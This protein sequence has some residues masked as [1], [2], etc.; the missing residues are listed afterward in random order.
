MN[1]Y[2]IRKIKDLRKISAI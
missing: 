2:E 1:G